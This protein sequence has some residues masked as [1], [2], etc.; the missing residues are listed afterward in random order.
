MDTPLIIPNNSKI[1]EIQKD[2]IK[3][4]LE[5]YIISNYLNINIEVIDSIPLIIFSNKFSKY[6][7]EQKS[8]IFK[9]NENIE[10]CLNIFEEFFNK[11]KYTLQNNENEIIIKITPKIFKLK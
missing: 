8:K 11:N 5:L 10:E 9:M 4:K 1:F 7:L 3:Y 6:D 2:S